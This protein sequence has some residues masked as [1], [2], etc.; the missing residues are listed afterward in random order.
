MTL[1]DS[2]GAAVTDQDGNPDDGHV[3][4]TIAADG[5]YYAEVESRALVYNGHEYRLTDGMN[6]LD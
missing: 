4:A 3:L 2:S 5:T 1:L 6:D